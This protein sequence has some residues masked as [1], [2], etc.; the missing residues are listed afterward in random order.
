MT[1][2][3]IDKKVSVPCGWRDSGPIAIEEIAR[4]DASLA[5][6]TSSCGHEVHSITCGMGCGLRSEGGAAPSVKSFSST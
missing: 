5:S 3:R 4:G 2:P 6:A 1:P